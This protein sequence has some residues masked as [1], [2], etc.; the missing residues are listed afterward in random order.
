[1]NLL[2][3]H[4]NIVYKVKAQECFLGKHHNL[5]IHAMTSYQLYLYIDILVKGNLKTILMLLLLFHNNC[6]NFINNIL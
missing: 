5:N 3:K 1:M 6:S 4:L 2:V